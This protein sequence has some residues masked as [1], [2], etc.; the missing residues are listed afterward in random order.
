MIFGVCTSK[1]SIFRDTFTKS[2]KA[3]KVLVVAIFEALYFENH[4]KYEFYSTHLIFVKRFK[5]LWAILFYYKC[6]V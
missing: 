3:L 1:L 4:Q 5:L 2:P 6:K